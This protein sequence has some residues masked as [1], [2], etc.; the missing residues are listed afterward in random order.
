MSQ[1]WVGNV[2]L[3]LSIVAGAGAQVA[4]K[5][6]MSL[7]G[8]LRLEALAPAHLNSIGAVPMALLSASLLVIGLGCWLVSLSRLDLTYAYPL[9]CASALLVT[10][11]G[12]VFLG[13]SVT[14]RMAIGVV[15]IVAGTALL[16]PAR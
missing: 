9:A 12:V 3:L 8:P 13:E 5:R 1:F 2:F 7:I 14:V 4:L 16:V 10:L 6:L 11:F 15:L